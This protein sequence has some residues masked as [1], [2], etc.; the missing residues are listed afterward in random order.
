ML[1]NFGETQPIGTAPVE[2]PGKPGDKPEPM[3]QETVAPDRPLINVS[4]TNLKAEIGRLEKHLLDMPAEG[5]QSLRDQAE[6][7]LMAAKRE[8]QARKPEGA[9][10]DQAIAHQRQASKA[11]TLAEAHV[12]DMKDGLSRAEVALQQAV[13]AETQA[14]Q[15]VQRVRSLISKHEPGSE[16]RMSAPPT[17]PSN[18][19]VGLYQFL[20][21]TGLSYTQLAQVGTLLGATVPPTPPAA[22]PLPAEPPVNERPGTAQQQ[23]FDK[24]QEMKRQA[25]ISLQQQGL[26]HPTNLA[27][28]LLGNTPTALAGTVPAQTPRQGRSPVPKRKLPPRTGEA[29]KASTYQS[30]SPSGRSASRTPDRGALRMEQTTNRDIDGALSPT[31]PPWGSAL[32]PQWRGAPSLILA[33]QRTAQASRLQAKGTVD[34]HMQQLSSLCPKLTP[35]ICQLLFL[36]VL[37]GFRDAGRSWLLFS[38]FLTHPDHIVFPNGIAESLSFLHPFSGR[39]G[40]ALLTWPTRVLPLLGRFLGLSFCASPE[41]RERTAVSERARAPPSCLKPSDAAP[42]TIVTAPVTR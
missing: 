25:V 8:L 40:L 36:V 21:T 5:F 33:S 35:F 28:Q 7:S 24:A 29:D 6:I 9:T 18:V 32:Q 20:Q 34:P 11:R 27:S 37:A 13:E 39:S 22:S 4:I 12:Q 14:T 19:L 3:E 17:V 16:V 15:E 10:L 2:H 30:P 42:A 26:T 38:C 1:R 31:L 23:D 41:L